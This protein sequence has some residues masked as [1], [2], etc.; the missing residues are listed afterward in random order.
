MDVGVGPKKK[1]LKDAE[2][3]GWMVNC[4]SSGEMNGEEWWWM[5]D[6]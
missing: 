3:V 4:S 5:G 2:M 1:G 6:G